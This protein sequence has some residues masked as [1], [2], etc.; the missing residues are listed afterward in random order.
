MVPTRDRI[1]VWWNLATV[2]GRTFSQDQQNFVRFSLHGADNLIDVLPRYPLL[3]IVMASL[4][5]VP[6]ITAA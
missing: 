2:L 1:D 6:S 3:T 5:L 4:R